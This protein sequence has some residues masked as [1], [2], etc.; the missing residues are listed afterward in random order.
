VRKRGQSALKEERA[1]CLV[2]Y[3]YVFRVLCIVVVRDKKVSTAE[4]VLGVE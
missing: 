2:V 1:Y 3:V 4:R